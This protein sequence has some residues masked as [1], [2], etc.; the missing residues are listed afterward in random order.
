MRVDAGNELKPTAVWHVES[1]PPGGRTGAALL[2]R[3]GCGRANGC[4][5]RFRHCAAVRARATLR[6]E[7]QAMAVASVS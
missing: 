7:T 6:K 1:G 5:V 3:D 2:D 4:P